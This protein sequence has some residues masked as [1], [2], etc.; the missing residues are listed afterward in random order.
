[1][2]GIGEGAASGGGNGAAVLGVGM[3][4]GGLVAGIGASPAGPAAGYGGGLPRLH[5]P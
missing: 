2:K 3:G 4:L 5:R 1:M